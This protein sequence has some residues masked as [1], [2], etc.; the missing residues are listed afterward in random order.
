MDSLNL[1]HG[2]WPKVNKAK[3]KGR[4]KAPRLCLRR[5]FSERDL[6]MRFILTVLI[7]LLSSSICAWEVRDYYKDESKYILLMRGGG[8]EELGEIIGK[9]ERVL[10]SINLGRLGEITSDNLQNEI[11]NYLEVN[12][13]NKLKTAYSSSGNMHNPKIIPLREPFEEA[14]TSSSFYQ[15]LNNILAEYGYTISGISMEKFMLIDR[16]NFD[17]MTW[18]DIEKLTNKASRTGDL[19][20]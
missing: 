14:F 16:K 5:W 4:G 15:S 12:Y 20:R 3:Q 18:L 17:A 19:T 2:H 6:V 8:L 13:S 10:S 1:S 9:K 11:L 7:F